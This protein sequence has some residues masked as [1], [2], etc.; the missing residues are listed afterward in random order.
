MNPASIQ[1]VLTVYL[2]ARETF[3]STLSLFKNKIK[4]YF[5]L[6]RSLLGE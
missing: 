6:K 2:K 4:F 1:I 3:A 5:L